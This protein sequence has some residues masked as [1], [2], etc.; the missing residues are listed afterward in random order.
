MKVGELA[1]LKDATT[2]ST[3]SRLEVI[4]KLEAQLASEREEARKTVTALNSQLA[5]READYQLVA[6]ELAQVKDVLSSSQAGAMD[7]AEGKE[8]ISVFLTQGAHALF[9]LFC[10]LKKIRCTHNRSSS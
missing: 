9:I 5:F 8:N 7:L 10:L 4:R 3:N 6:N 2:R 1:S